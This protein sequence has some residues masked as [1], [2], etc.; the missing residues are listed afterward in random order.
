MTVTPLSGSEEARGTAYSPAKLL[1]RC[2]ICKK[3]FVSEAQ[4]AFHRDIEHVKH[5]PVSGVA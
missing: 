4:L 3:E 2:E 1:F 5:L